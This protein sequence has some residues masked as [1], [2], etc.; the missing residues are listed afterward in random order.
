MIL[1]L[2]PVTLRQARAFVFDHHRHHPKV[3][4]GLFAVALLRWIPGSQ[5][6]PELVGVAIGG[7]PVAG[8][9]QDG[10]TLE[11]LRCCVLPGMPNGCSML[12]RALVRAGEALGYRRFITYTL[13]TEHARSLKAAGFT[14]VAITRGGAWS[15]EARRRPRADHEGRKVRWEVEPASAKSAECHGRD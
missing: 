6:G 8:G 1:E 2:A 13:E 11:V 7:R 15:R 3:T 14:A 4:G 5:A 9:L 10:R 12:Y